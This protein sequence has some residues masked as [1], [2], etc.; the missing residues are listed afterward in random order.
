M[1]ERETNEEITTMNGNTVAAT[2]TQTGRLGSAGWL[3]LALAGALA[4]LALLFGLRAESASAKSDIYVFKSFP[5][6][7]QAGG[8]PDIFTE[9]ELGSR[10]TTNPPVPCFC[11]DPK[12][13]IQHLP[14]GVVANPHVVAEC[15]IAQL[16]LFEC[17]TDSQAG[18]VVLQLFGFG[19]FPLYRTTPAAGQAGLFAFLLP[20]GAAAP[21]YL[22]FSSR[23]GGDYGLDVK[24]IG[25]SHLL[26]LRYY[27]PIFWGVPNDHFYDFLRFKPGNDGKEGFQCEQNPFQP[28]VEHN[29]QGVK[30]LCFYGLEGRDVPSSLP[31]APML[32]NPTR[33]AGPM[34]TKMEVFSYDLEWSEAEWDWPETTGCDA[35]SFDPSLAANPTT[36]NTDSASGV[37]V[38]IEVPQFQDPNTPSPSELR[39]S[40]MTLPPGF[41][42]NPS[43]ADGKVTCSDEQS[44]VGTEEEANC[45]EFSKVGTVTLDSS[46]LPAPI[47]GFVYLGEPKPGEPY[48]M[49]V[50]ANGFGT[51][52][53]LLG[54][55]HADEKTG[56]VVVAFEDVPQ[57]TFD[58]DLPQTPFQEFVLHIFGSE[59]GILATPTE[60]GRYPVTSRFVPWDE[61]LSDQEQTQ[62]FELDHG[63]NGGACPGATRDFSPSFEA[64]TRS[65]TAGA[66]TSFAL[67][68]GRDDGDQG[69]DRVAITTPPGFLASLRGVSYCPESAIATLTDGSHDGR[70]EQAGPA[71]PANS[72]VGTA[73]TAAGAGTK[74]LNTPGKVYLA[75]PYE[76][77]PL[78][79]VVV[80]P[81]VAGPYDL[82]NVAVRAAVNVDPAT[83]Q[84][85]AV[86]DPLPQI[87][88]GIPLRLRVIQ[89]SLDRQNFALNP[90]N[91]A[92][93]SVQTSLTGDQGTVA[94]PSANF[95]VANC[96]DLDYQPKLSLKLRGGVNRLG[97]PAIRATLRTT[98]GEANSKRVSVTLP[99]GELLDNKHIG[100]VCTRPQFAADKC[101]DASRIG[102]A[103][104][105]S[106]LLDDAVTGGVYLRASNHRLPDM[107][108]DLEGQ[109]DVQLSAQID[110]AKGGRLR[111]TFA[112]IPD[113]P[114]QRF[115]MDLQGGKKGL[116]QNSRGL[117]GKRKKAK[118]VMLGQNGWRLRDHVRLQV[119]CGS[120]GKRKRHAKH[121]R[122]AYRAGA[123]R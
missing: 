123:V 99:G 105:H 68:I 103:T 6:T 10:L 39:K 91:C 21:Q 110:S 24:S 102:T 73:D 48:R 86:S 51:A 32:Q 50:T 93:F 42:L 54:T 100:T 36:T 108:A 109:V 75:G 62:F 33:C 85:S 17:P 56:Q 30:E 5:S 72:Q 49:V 69:L 122:R 82:G 64:G 38:K 67:R 29:E 18:V 77:A 84:V 111:A 112:G 20:F 40:R 8:H 4:A 26:P 55:V 11:N 96:T 23:T 61:A 44:A 117:C 1:A 121:L 7:T 43:A 35:L 80:V 118:V 45:P 120:K 74:P 107:V 63:P 87:V 97:H 94:T 95:Q 113:V 101:P 47:D 37:E 116:L 12:E 104:A 59:R 90:T 3:A 25:I 13:V 41:S 114:V 14:P 119:A 31:I 16:A 79:L 76:G 65:N 66:H 70:A 71:C 98:P 22:T 2:T 92:P 58:E 27:A 115:V 60:C 52:V 46:A 28:M 78:S 15:K 9:F 83:T 19:G 89:V 106:Q 81:A 34:K 53:K 57:T 88:G